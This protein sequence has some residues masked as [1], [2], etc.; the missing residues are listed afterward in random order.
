MKCQFTPKQLYSSQ[1]NV[2]LEYTLIFFQRLSSSCTQ[3]KPISNSPFI[4]PHVNFKGWL[5]GEAQILKN[6]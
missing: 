1:I 5:L 3:R 6:E 4:V 2:L